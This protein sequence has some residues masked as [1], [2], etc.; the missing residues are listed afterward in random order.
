MILNFIL[1]ILLVCVLISGL[2]SC[3]RFRDNMTSTKTESSKGNQNDTPPTDTPPPVTPP[4]ENPFPTDTTPSDKPQNDDPS[5]PVIPPNENPSPTDTT[6]SDEPQDDDPSPPVIPP[7]DT[8]SPTDTTPSDEPQDEDSTPSTALKKIT[9]LTKRSN[10]PSPPKPWKLSLKEIINAGFL[11]DGSSDLLQYYIQYWFNNI[12]YIMQVLRV[13]RNVE[14]L[15]LWNTMCHESDCSNGLDLKR[16][17]KSRM[18][19][20]IAL[21]SYMPSSIIRD[22]ENPDSESIFF[23]QGQLAPPGLEIQLSNQQNFDYKS[24]PGQPAYIQKTLQLIE[25]MKQKNTKII[26]VNIPFQLHTDS[27]PFKLLGNFIKSNKLDLHIIGTCEDYCTKYLIPAAKTIYIEPYG[28]I[29]S[30]G[31]FSTL[32]DEF[33]GI[34]TGKMEELKRNIKNKGPSTLEEKIQTISSQIHSTV[35]SDNYSE[36]IDKFKQMNPKTGVDFEKSLTDFYYKPQTSQ[37]L[38]DFTE[39]ERKQFL[40][41]LSTGVL[42]DLLVFVSLN[43][44]QNQHLAVSTN[45]IRDT[46]FYL[47]ALESDYYE[48]RINI[49]RLNS[50][51]SYTFSDLLQLAAYLVKNQKYEEYFSTELRP[52]YNI[53]EKD[54]PYYMIVPSAELLISLG[55][56]IRGKNN[57]EGLGIDKNSR[58]VF[59]YLDTKR[60]KNCKFFEEGASYT[61]KTLQDCLFKDADQ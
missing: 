41:G 12:E 10:F 54:K 25:I 59:L 35:N 45:Y 30:N 31:S 2:I 38:V 37:N 9:S 32:A 11:K 43:N 50:T 8:P 55:I 29:Y 36:F 47:K 34:V 42:S 52:Y 16:I 20:I 26:T 13:T 27:R 28:H 17:D 48:R 44:S 5:P 53:P 4:N 18:E 56:D 51:Q 33:S 60:I 23:L 58:E 46:L 1:K 3:E 61:T 15:H 21:L 49:Q 22:E 40:E 7:N 19:T 6:P 57:I 14:H 39:E 24:Q